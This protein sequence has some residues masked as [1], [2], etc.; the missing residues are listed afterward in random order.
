M[1][2]LKKDYIKMK[3]T[4][5]KVKDYVQFPK[6]KSSVKLLPVLLVQMMHAIYQLALIMPANLEI[7][8]EK[9]FISETDKLTM[10]QPPLMLHIKN[11]KS[12]LGENT[13]IDQ[14]LT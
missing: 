6:F 10:L 4:V 11:F 1:S 14:L 2:H 9:L 3:F 8:L 13:P 7:T 12:S 5:T